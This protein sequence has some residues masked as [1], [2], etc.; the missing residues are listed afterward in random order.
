MRSAYSEM[1]RAHDAGEMTPTLLG[2]LGDLRARVQR[3]RVCLHAVL[4]SEVLQPETGLTTETCMM[5]FVAGCDFVRH[6]AGERLET[7]PARRFFETSCELPEFLFAPRSVGS[8]T[9][10]ELD[11]CFGALFAHK[12]RVRWGDP[13]LLELLAAL[14]LRSSLLLCELEDRN[15]RRA[16][17]GCALVRLRLLIAVHPTGE[18]APRDIAPSAVRAYVVRV[19]EQWD[20]ARLREAIA[21]ACMQR[22]MRMHEVARTASFSGQNPPCRSRGCCGKPAMVRAQMGNAP[23]APVN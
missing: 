12:R 11:A 21:R 3:A 18:L 6:S 4:F 19:I 20:G 16:L 9:A 5:T 1:L 17:W 10:A 2:Q 7:E 23:V 22:Q 8:L 13:E 14:Q 15:G